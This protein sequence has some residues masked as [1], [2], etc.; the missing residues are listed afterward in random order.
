MNTEN[1]QFSG[2]VIQEIMRRKAPWIQHVYRNILPPELYELAK[3]DQQME[4]VT[5]WAKE[6][7]YAWRELTGESQMLKAGMVIA[8]FRPFLSGE[9]K[10]RK[11]DF[12]AMVMGRKIVFEDPQQN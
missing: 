2:W 3:K 1:D 12:S 10:D 8:Y 7:G 9:G 5:K 6:Q 4:R 11:L